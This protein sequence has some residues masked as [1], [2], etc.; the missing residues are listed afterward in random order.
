MYICIY[1]Y[2]YIYNLII[3]RKKK[4]NDRNDNIVYLTVNIRQNI[5]KY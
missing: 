5:H 1:I 2:I 3:N 4:H